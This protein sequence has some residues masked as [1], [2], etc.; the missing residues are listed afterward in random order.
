MLW[1]VNYISIKLSCFVFFFKDH[2]GWWWG[3]SGSREARSA[4]TGFKV[5]LAKY[6]WTP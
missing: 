2:S 5:A 6:L 4:I 1:Q 3:Q